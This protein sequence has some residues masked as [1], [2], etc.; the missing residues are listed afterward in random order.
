MNLINPTTYLKVPEG[1]I[2]KSN[3]FGFLP[4]VI[5]WYQLKSLNIE[6]KLI[7]GKIETLLFKKFGYSHSSTWRKI[8]NLVDYGWLRPDKNEYK[9]ISYQ[10]FFCKLGYKFEEKIDIK[11][12]NNVIKNYKPLFKINKIE[13]S[14]LPYFFEYCA[15]QDIKFNFQKQA[16]VILRQIKK[17]PGN[18]IYQSIIQKKILEKVKL[19]DIN[20]F[21]LINQ[22]IIESRKEETWKKTSD[23]DITLSCQGLSKLLGYSSSYTGH[24]IQQRLDYLGL[25]KVEKRKV[26]METTDFFALPL[27]RKYKTKSPNFVYNNGMLFYFNTNKIWLN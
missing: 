4:D 23:F 20:S 21:D 12:Y 16:Y 5:F 7:K 6:G 1:L 11:G 10:L 17:N 8:K 9:I 26:L 3:Q 27:Y 2:K 19:S 13:V 25:I 24:A 15:Y 14:K 22:F 18:P